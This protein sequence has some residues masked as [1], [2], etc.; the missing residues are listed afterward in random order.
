MSRLTDEDLV[1]IELVKRHQSGSSSSEERTTRA[2]SM[3][4]GVPQV[5]VTTNEL[6]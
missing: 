5:L 4:A 6:D 2:D 1:H 3:M